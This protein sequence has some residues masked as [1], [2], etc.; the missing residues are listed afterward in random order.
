MIEVIMLQVHPMIIG[1]IGINCPIEIAT[2]AIDNTALTI[3]IG[4]ITT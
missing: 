3:K 1:T 4:N 2:I